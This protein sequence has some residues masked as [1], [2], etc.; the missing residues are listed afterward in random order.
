MKER[1]DG[2]LVQVHVE[3]VQ[4]EGKYRVHNESP[5]TATSHWTRAL[6]AV[7]SE[8]ENWPLI[9]IQLCVISQVDS[10]DLHERVLC[11]CCWRI[12]YCRC[13]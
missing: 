5:L 10:G 1:R 7:N 6:A 13:N 9:E 8:V 12:K 4:W 3:M 2:K 11:E